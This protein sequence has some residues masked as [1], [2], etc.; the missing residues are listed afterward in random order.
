MRNVE[1]DMVATAFTETFLRSQVMDFTSLCVFSDY[2]AFSY[3]KPSFRR[4]NLAAFILPFDRIVWLCGVIVVCF[5]SCLFCWNGNRDSIF[6]SKLESCWFTIGAALQQGS[7]LSPGSC[8][9]R[10]LAASLWCTM[11]T[12]AAVYSGNL[13]ACLAVSNLNTPF[14][15]FAD[16]TQQNEYQMG[17]IGGSVNESLFGEGELEPY[18][19]IGR[20]IYAAE[21]TDPSVLSRDVAA[22]LKR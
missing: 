3:K 2:K 22:H 6:K 12:L 15:T 19:T 1:A 17:M 11:V 10:V 4:A 5:V 16:L 21:A 14:T 20:R 18:R 7:P 8:S 9:G 13:T